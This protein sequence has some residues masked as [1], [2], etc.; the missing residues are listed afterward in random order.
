MLTHSEEASTLGLKPGEWPVQLTYGNQL[1]GRTAWECS[2]EGEVL[3]V[4][5]LSTQTDDILVVLND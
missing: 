2:P 3:S 4:K 1:Y 5:Y